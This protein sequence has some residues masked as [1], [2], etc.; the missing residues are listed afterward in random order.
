MGTRYDVSEVPLQGG[1]VAKRCPVRGQ[2]DA[3]RPCEP[4]PPSETVERRL[5]LGRDFETSILAQLQEAH[6]DLVVV[7]GDTREEREAATMNAIHVGAQLIFGGRL[8][9]DTAGRRVGEPDLLVRTGHSDPPTYRAVDVKHHRTLEALTKTPAHCSELIQPSL[10]A[11][12]DDPL[13]SARKHRDDLLQLA[14]YQRMLEAAGVAAEDPWGGIAGVE[15]K[16]VWQNLDVPMWLT[17]S[18]TGKKKQ[19]STME[20][21]D[22]EFNFRLDIIAVAQQ[23]QRDGSVEPLL[24]PVRIGECPD[25]PW[26]VHCGPLLEAGAGDVS[27]LPRIG[28]REWRIHRDHGVNDRAE[29]ARLDP[30]TAT[31]VASGIDI[32]SVLDAARSAEPSTPITELIGGRRPTQT[33]RLTEAGI[34]TAADTLTLCPATAKYS[35]CGLSSLPQQIDLAR[36][37]LAPDPVYKRRGIKALD[38]P[39][40]DVEV[41]LDLENVEDGVY[42]WGALITDRSGAGVETGYKAFVSWEPMQEKVEVD[43]FVQL[44]G[45]L[46]QLRSD[47]TSRGKTF[48]AYCYNAGAESGHLRRLA[49]LANRDTEVDEFLDSDEWVDLLR[50]FDSHLITG[51]G[52]GLKAIAPLAGYEWTVDDPGGAESML[53]Y[54]MAVTADD[55]DA[56]DT[57]REWLLTYNRGDVEATLALRNWLEAQAT[58]IP[59]IE[60]VNRLFQRDPA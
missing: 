1:Y 12:V 6:P 34:D 40:A 27:L 33:A 4:L 59:G 25:C 55:E 37:A 50:V 17:P 15:G 39:R 53:R 2:N 51:A 24:V 22:F 54:D 26:W 21:Y 41:D 30:R 11:A 49:K 28:W 52:V 56:R 13:M 14:H 38:V 23:H 10:E 7:T 48:V 47:V 45:W 3:L 43:N 8:A 35:G 58:E 9:P 46:T 60:S 44:W 31:L 20:V 18:S 42:L 5:A 19:R 32:A 29:L 57:A 16:V 36:A